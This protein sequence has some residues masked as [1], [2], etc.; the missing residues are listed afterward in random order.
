MNRYIFNGNMLKA[1]QTAVARSSDPVF[2][3]TRTSSHQRAIVNTQQI[4][5]THIEDADAMMSYILG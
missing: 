5:P 2:N 3:P 4:D 1:R